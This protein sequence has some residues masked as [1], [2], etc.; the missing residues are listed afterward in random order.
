M[1]LTLKLQFSTPINENLLVRIYQENDDLVQVDLNQF[2][3]M[4]G[5]VL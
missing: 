5:S 3:Q 2:I 1:L 4:V